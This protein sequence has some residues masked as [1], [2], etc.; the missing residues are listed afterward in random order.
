MGMESGLWWTATCL[1]CVACVGHGALGVEGRPFEVEGRP[2]GVEGL[3]LGCV[4]G[5]CPRGEFVPKAWVPQVTSPQPHAMGQ[6]EFYEAAK[7]VHGGEEALAALYSPQLLANDLTG[8][9]L[10]RPAGAV[11]ASFDWRKVRGRSYVTRNLNQHVPVYCGS[12]WAH[13]ALS[14]LADRIKIARRAAWPDIEL[15]VQAVLNCAVHEAGSCRGGDS[16]ALYQWLSQHGVPDETCQPYEAVDR[17]CLPLNVCRNCQ[18]PVG[19]PSACTAVPEGEFTRWWVDEYGEISGEEA[20]QKEIFLRGPIACGIDA[21]VMHE[22]PDNGDI[23]RDD[24]GHRQIDHIISIAGWGEEADPATG[25]LIK[26]WRVRNSWGAYAG[27]DGWF[28]VERGK[29]VAAIE[30]YCTWA[31]AKLDE[32]GWSAGDAHKPREEL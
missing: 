6:A 3:P 16:G 22:R 25:E 30:D 31:T 10:G 17:E 26:Y 15:S 18:P 23:I 11:P 1:A 24:G 8:P 14:A 27:S 9:D 32:D 19:D 28:R 13:G 20:M 2:L 5:R 21:T 29:D 4:N 12:C 7:A